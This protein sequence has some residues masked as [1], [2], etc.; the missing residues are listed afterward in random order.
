MKITGKVVQVGTGLVSQD[1]LAYSASIMCQEISGPSIMNAA[2]QGSQ[3]IGIKSELH[4]SS[5]KPFEFTVGDDVEIE[6]LKK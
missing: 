4:L 1:K 2:G 6:V 3:P 5:F